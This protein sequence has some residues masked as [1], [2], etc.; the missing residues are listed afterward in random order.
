[1]SK[2]SDQQYLKTAQYKDASNLNARIELHKRF[3]TN[4]YGWSRWVFDIYL[5]RLPA[6][7]RI[8]EVGC[9]PA[10]IWR[11]NSARIPVG[12][13]ITLSDF[14]DGMLD[15]AWRNLVVTGRT[16][17]FEQI[18]AQSIPYP[19]ET[20]DVVIANHM[21]YHVTDR[22]KAIGEIYRVLKPGGRLIATTVGDQHMDEINLWLKHLGKDPAQFLVPF[23]LESGMVQLQPY[24][25]KV[26]MRRYVDS[27]QITE[28]E[29]LMTYIS[30]MARFGDFPE[31]AFADLRNELARQLQSKDM[32]VVRKDSGLFDAVK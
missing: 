2:I 21:L 32:L 22:P 13:T 3:S 11:E 30:S 28:V 31:A 9:G 18:D 6:Q 10:T 23:T 14:S 19:E 24:F 20:F 5:E 25:S 27:L 15:S 4:T 7:A 8:L 1:M 16:F 12:W 26:E 17:K 29:P